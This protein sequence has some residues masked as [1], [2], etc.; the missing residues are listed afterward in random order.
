ML[1]QTNTNFIGMT[2]YQNVITIL[3]WYDYILY[4]IY[5]ILISYIFCT[6]EI[7]SSLV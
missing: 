7:P 5:Y 1:Y 4:T 6:K 2:I 3:Y